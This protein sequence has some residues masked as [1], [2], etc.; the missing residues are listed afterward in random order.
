MGDENPASSRGTDADVTGSTH[1]GRVITIDRLRADPSTGLSMWQPLRHVFVPARGEDARDA[2]EGAGGEPYDVS[3]LTPEERARFLDLLAKARVGGEVQSLG[4]MP[5]AEPPSASPPD[6]PPA[7]AAR[8]AAAVRPE[9]PPDLDPLA[10]ALAR[11]RQRKA[12]RWQ[13]ASASRSGAPGP[14]RAAANGV[15]EVSGSR[16]ARG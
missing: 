11:N 12:E 6:A 8:A 3:R 13:I 14:G 1:G 15:A 9:P 2:P 7:A 16:A 4:A 5:P 10:L